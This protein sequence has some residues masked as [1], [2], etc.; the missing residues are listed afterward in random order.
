MARMAA[1]GRAGDP[2]EIQI[3][4]GIAGERRLTEM[5][6]MAARLRGLKAG[7][8]RQR[9]PPSSSSSMSTAKWSTLCYLAATLARRRSSRVPG[10]AERALRRS[11]RE[12]LAE[13]DEGI[14]EVRGPPALHPFQGDGMGR[15]RPRDPARR[16]VRPR[17]AGGPLDGD[18]RRRSTPRSAIK[19]TTPAQH[20]HPVL[21]RRRSST[22]R[23]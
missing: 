5:S 23:C 10:P 3:M 2:A 22:P 1:A 12:G 21:R 13:P 19:A 9:A 6:S 11:R 16:A 4:Y 15:L 8:G 17:R 18:P 7:P 14:W 20:V